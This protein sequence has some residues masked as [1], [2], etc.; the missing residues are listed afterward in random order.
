MHTAPATDR[1]V[2]QTETRLD[3]TVLEKDVQRYFENGLAAA[4]RRTYQAGIN[5]FIKFCNSYNVSSPLPVSVSVLYSYISHLANSGLSYST[6]KTYLTSLIYTLVYIMT[7][8]LTDQQTEGILLDPA[9]CM[10]AWVVI[11]ANDIQNTC[12]N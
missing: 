5:K 1:H 10:R 3:L 6:I 7:D 8:R 11:Y 12:I 4:T 9:S 2:D